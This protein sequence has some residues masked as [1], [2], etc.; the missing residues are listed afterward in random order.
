MRVHVCVC[1]CVCIYV[2]VCVCVCVCACVRVCVCLDKRVKC[3]LAF[4]KINVF[5]ERTHSH[6]K[7]CTVQYVAITS[8]RLHKCHLS[9]CCSTPM[10]SST[11]SAEAIIERPGLETVHC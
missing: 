11:A 10:S 8:F 5:S 7:I 4:Y 6:I 3:L 2:C 1:M 9:G